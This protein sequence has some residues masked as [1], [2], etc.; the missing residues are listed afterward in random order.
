[1]DRC[2]NMNGLSAYEVNSTKFMYYLYC[3]AIALAIKN[4]KVWRN[5]KANI[6]ILEFKYYIE[7]K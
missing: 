5:S 1:M 7:Y 3:Y 6:Y 4:F 2:R